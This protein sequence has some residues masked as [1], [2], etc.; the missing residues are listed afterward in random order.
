MSLKNYKK[1]LT[2]GSCSTKD[3]MEYQILALVGVAQKIAYDSKKSSDK[4]N[5][6]NRETKKEWPA[7]IRYFLP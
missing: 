7:Y 5:T 3:T 6:S 1:L 4:F 2:S